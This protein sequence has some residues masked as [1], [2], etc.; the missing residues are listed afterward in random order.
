MT[1][2]GKA[3]CQYENKKLNIEIRSLNSKQADVSVRIPLVYNEK[4]IEIRNLTVERLQRGKIE[5]TIKND[6]PEDDR[7]TQINSDKVKNYYQQVNNIS[8][9]LG[10]PLKES[11]T[12]LATILRFPDVLQIKQE[13]INENEWEAL[14]GK[15]TE[16]IE[17]LISFRQ[18]EGK[19]L[20]NDIMQRV[21]NILELLKKIEPFEN[22]RIETIK[23]RIAN[24]LNE[25]FNN[26]NID[27]NRYEQELIYYLEKFDLNEE[28]VRLINHCNYF[29]ETIKNNDAVGRKL[30]FIGQEMGREINTIGSKAN[31]SEIQKIVVQMKDELEKI[32]EQVLNIL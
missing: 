19:S 21:N 10:N 17:H 28:K 23:T 24:N 15:I 29:I 14:K 20:E 26:V 32:K 6:S 13:S 11:E 7:T 2:Y 27:K 3:V 8:K 25:H 9:E 18:T 5:L 1:G 4:E 12:I 16:A 30:N 31:H 22:Q